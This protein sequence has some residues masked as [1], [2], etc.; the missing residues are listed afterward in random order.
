M[1]GN[2]ENLNK[3]LRDHPNFPDKYDLMY[4]RLVFT[5]LQDPALTLIQAYSHLKEGGIIAIDKF[6]LP[7]CEGHLAGIINHLREAGYCVMAECTRNEVT[8]FVIKKTNN[9]NELV[10]PLAFNTRKESGSLV[11]Q[12][13]PTIPEDNKNEK[14]LEKESE[15][16][17]AGRLFIKKELDSLLKEEKNRN[18]SNFFN[19]FK[20]GKGSLV[21]LLSDERY[22][23]LSSLKMKYF[24]L[25][26]CVAEE[27]NVKDFIKLR[28]DTELNE[29]QSI[30]S[31]FYTISDFCQQ[32]SW[33]L[34]Q[35]SEK[36]GPEKFNQLFIRAALHDILLFGKRSQ[37]W[38]DINN[39]GLNAGF[40][41]SAIEY[42]GNIRGNTADNKDMFSLPET[43]VAVQLQV[44]KK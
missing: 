23:N 12:L 16:L 6:N 5:H 17:Q 7:G 18:E 19:E 20:K 9:T 30:R 37:T 29:F 25:L 33:R 15:A 26:N 44:R 39:Y 4:S 3:E 22:K 38:K 42:P 1:R 36:L 11:Y 32:G 8:N 13:D 21:G 35:A 28:D 27:L 31:D 10:L 2:L 34:Q 41:S 24:I 14:L 40:A 43:V